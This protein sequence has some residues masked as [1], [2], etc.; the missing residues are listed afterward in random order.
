[1]GKNNSKLVK[2]IGE[3]NNL[4]K[5]VIDGKVEELSELK[6]QRDERK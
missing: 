4:L 5:K 2:D 1:M 6:R 3:V